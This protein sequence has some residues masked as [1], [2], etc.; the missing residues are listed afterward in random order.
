[1]A[2]AWQPVLQQEWEECAATEATNPCCPGCAR[3]LLPTGVGAG[4]TLLSPV[5]PS[6][7]QLLPGHCHTM[8]RMV[9]GPLQG[10]GK[11][12][13][14]AWISAPHSMWDNTPSIPQILCVLWKQLP[15]HPV[16]HRLKEGEQGTL[17]V[18]LSTDWS[19][20]HPTCPGWPGWK[21][22]LLPHGLRHNA[23]K[24]MSF[25]KVINTIPRSF[26][27]DIPSLT[28]SFSLDDRYIFVKKYN[29][30]IKIN[31]QK[32]CL[33]WYCATINQPSLSNQ[34]SMF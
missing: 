27:D 5:L 11:C 32:L 9:L 10:N 12:P 19:N 1:M 31:Q 3:L 23:A 4:Q 25:C 20:A 8:G 13:S 33:L 28:S 17:S 30:T 29:P 16:R 7:L 21:I 26:Y 15:T 34:T 14:P 24:A 22:I 6:L 2:Q 18:L